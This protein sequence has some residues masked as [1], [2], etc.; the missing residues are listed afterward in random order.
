MHNR[1]GYPYPCFT[2]KMLPYAFYSNFKSLSCCTLLTFF[3][4]IISKANYSGHNAAF[5]TS[6][7]LIDIRYVHK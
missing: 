3:E 1:R 4:D 5:Q 6:L 7:Y 2:L